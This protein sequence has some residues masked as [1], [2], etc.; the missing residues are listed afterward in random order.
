MGQGVETEQGLGAPCLVV[1][2]SKNASANYEPQALPSM[3]YSR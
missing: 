2:V 1:R 3:A